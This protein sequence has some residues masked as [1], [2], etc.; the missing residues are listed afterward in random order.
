[1]NV[2]RKIWRYVI[3]DGVPRR[4]FAIALVVGTVVNLIDQ[5][6]A[7]LDGPPFDISKLLL[8]YLAFYCVATCGLVSYRLNADRHR[9]QGNGRTIIVS[10]EK[11]PD[12]AGKTR[13]VQ[14]VEVPPGGR[15]PEH[16]HGGPTTTTLL[17][18]TV[19]MQLL[20][21]PARV[22]RACETL[23]EPPGS[24]HHAENLSLTE[25]A[26]VLL[27]HVADDGAQLVVFH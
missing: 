6:D 18:G 22:Y 4:S 19:R 15:I 5:G 13:T 9:S 16:H 2:I 17:S 11:I 1:M 14:V 26:Q 3:S 23:Y 12:V 24:V 10:Q 27:I 8:T 21:G 7:I 25:P 20:G